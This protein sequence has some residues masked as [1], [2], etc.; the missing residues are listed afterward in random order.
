MA[1]FKLLSRP[2]LLHLLFWACL[3]ALPILLGPSSQSQ[4]PEEV[5]RHFQWNLFFFVFGLAN[6]PIFYINT[7]ILIPK[8]LKRQKLI[9]YLLFLLLGYFIMVGLNDLIFEILFKD[10]TLPQR[11]RGGGGGMKRFSERAR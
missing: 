7:E 1:K 9:V 10:L 2:I 5:Q 8:V 3:L 6:I 11:P 4:N